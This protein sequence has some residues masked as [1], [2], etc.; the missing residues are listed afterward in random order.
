MAVCALNRHEPASG[1]QFEDNET[2]Q[3][4]TYRFLFILTHA[5]GLAQ[6][7]GDGKPCGDYSLLLNTTVSL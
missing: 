2:P 4:S 5:R 3:G 6:P 7:F 1:F